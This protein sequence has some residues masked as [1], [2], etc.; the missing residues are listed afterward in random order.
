YPVLP[1][2]GSAKL[3]DFDRWLGQLSGPAGAV[4]AHPTVAARALGEDL[5][6]PQCPSRKSAGGPLHEADGLEWPLRL[7]ALWQLVS[8]APMRRTQQGEFFK[9]DLDRLLQDPLLNAPPVENLAEL[10]DS[11]LLAVALAQA[12]GIIEEKQGELLAVGLPARWEE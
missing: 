10:P 12:E 8:A 7:A 5:G 11:G 9:R 4:F 2:A 6:L 3:K 1:E